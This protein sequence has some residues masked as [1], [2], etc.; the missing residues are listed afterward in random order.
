[1]IV[2][3]S[4]NVVGDHGLQMRGNSSLGLGQ[5]CSRHAALSGLSICKYVTR[6]RREAAGCSNN[7]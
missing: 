4:T 6:A 1:M 3:S 2:I 7:A 5:T